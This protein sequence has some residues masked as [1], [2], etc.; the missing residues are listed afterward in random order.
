MD[1]IVFIAEITG[2]VAFAVAGT[3]VGVKHELDIIGAIFTGCTTAVGG[4]VIRDVI[5]GYIPPTIFRR[6]VYAAVAAATSLLVALAEYF[7]SKKKLPE[8]GSYDRAVNIFDAAGLAVFIVAGIK[9]TAR[10]GYG[11]NAFLSIF[12]ASVG[13][14]GGGVMRDLLVDTV[15]MILRK[16]VY[17]T[18]AIVGAIIY[19]HVSAFGVKDYILIPALTVAMVAV[20]VLAAE[21]RWN[22]PRFRNNRKNGKDIP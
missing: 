2:V 14:L 6:P 15:P 4:G 20:R 1:I 13:A 18:P 17:A 12:V 3:L 5:L 10:Q 22:L 8:F 9:L 19:Y 11:D 7:I 16:Q 21:F